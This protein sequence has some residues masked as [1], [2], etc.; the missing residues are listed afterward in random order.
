MK[1][2]RQRAKVRAAGC[3]KEEEKKAKGKEGA[4]SS[5][6]K[7]V[8][9]GAPKRKVDGKDNRPPKRM[10]VTLGEKLP[11]KPLP[12]KPSHGAGKGLMTTQ[13]L[14][15]RNLIIVFLLTRTMPLR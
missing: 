3:R 8:G 7:V 12:P 10:S 15:F 13:A 9:K 2:T 11:K 4:S 1:L 6:L 5:T 14:S